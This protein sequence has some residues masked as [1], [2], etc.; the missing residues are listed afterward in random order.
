M[1]SYRNGDQGGDA[2]VGRGK[3]QIS[4]RKSALP[5]ADPGAFVV[6]KWRKK[7]CT[8][9]ELDDDKILALAEYVVW[10][11]RMV[12]HGNG[13]GRGRKEISDQKSLLPEADPSAL[14]AHKWR[15][16]L[17]VRRWRKKLC[18]P[19]G[20]RRR[21]DPGAGGEGHGADPEAFILSINIARRHLDTGQIAI[22]VAKAFPN[23]EK[24]GRGKKGTASGGFPT[25]LHQRLAEARVIVRHGS[26]LADRVLGHLRR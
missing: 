11:D 4:E 21:Q 24:G 1:F 9:G 12:V 3:K 15:K 23:A 25:V 26:E 5:D 10:R 22:V 14:I 6:H 13:P 16:K 7:L 2:E 8:R 19:R 17:A 20:A 18:T